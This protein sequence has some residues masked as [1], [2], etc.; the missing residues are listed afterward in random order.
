MEM[1]GKKFG[2]AKYDWPHNPVI[3]SFLYSGIIGGI[4]FICF[5]IMVIA[6]YIIYLKR[7]LFFFISFIITFFFVFFSD[8]SLF[9]TPLFTLLCLIPFLTKYLYFKEIY[10]DTQKIQLKRILFW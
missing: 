10:S 4:L 8:T 1:Y 6:N 2:E 9:N 7:H 5:L 3:S